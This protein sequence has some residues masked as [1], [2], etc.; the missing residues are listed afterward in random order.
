LLQ[1]S[2]FVGELRGRKLIER[3]IQIGRQT[4]QLYRADAYGGALE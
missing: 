4:R 3:S 1:L 2:Y